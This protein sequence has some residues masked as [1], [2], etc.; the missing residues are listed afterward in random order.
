[1]HTKYIA[2]AAFAVS[3]A[4]AARKK[5][6]DAED[7][8]AACTT[9]CQFALD[10]TRTCDDENRS[11][12]DF[13]LCVCGAPNAQQ[14]LVQCSTCISTGVASS[15]TGVA[16]ESSPPVVSLERR[17]ETRRNLARS[18]AYRSVRGGKSRR[19]AMGDDGGEGVTQEARSDGTDNEIAGSSNEDE[20]DRTRNRSPLDKLIKQ[21]DFKGS[22]STFPPPA[23]PS[24]TLPPAAPSSALPVVPIVDPP[25]STDPTSSP[26]PSEPP[27]PPAPTQ[28][29][30]L[31][32]GPEA[33]TQGPPP[34]ETTTSLP[35]PP[36][37]EIP[38]DLPSSPPVSAPS[39]PGARPP[40]STPS[41][42]PSVGL[43]SSDLPTSSP[44]GDTTLSP[45]LLPSPTTSATSSSST[46]SPPA[47]P[48]S[49]P[50]SPP[51]GETPG[52]GGPGDIG[53]PPPL[54]PLLP[55]PGGGELDDPMSQPQPVGE[56]GQADPF[57]PAPPA[58]P[59]S[60]AT[61]ATPASPVPPGGGSGPG[62]GSP[63]AP[64]P[65]AGP[66][67]GG[68]TSS[69]VPGEPAQTT[70]SEPLLPI[71]TAGASELRAALLWLALVT[72]T[73]GVIG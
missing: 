47:G 68:N 38:T 54:G 24:T 31:P 12:D 10:Q 2:L 3:T 36:P 66:S 53:S 70:S 48:P 20:Q 71:P 25:V 63:S 62:V 69:S 9:L 43:P 57:P 5:V 19:V 30:P 32:T 34:G 41:A 23:I 40:V 46:P 52:G 61:P 45:S 51:S 28:P 72:L 1:M 39:D 29:T 37:V 60:T 6:L 15:A 18:R 73:V 27:S 50:A 16:D 22:P 21:C 33:P 65:A 11:K 8:P 49:P 35:S 59:T 26:A 42:E 17:K 64:P 56:P 67:G 44:G 4:T 55:L 13:L 58:S 14:L 7:V